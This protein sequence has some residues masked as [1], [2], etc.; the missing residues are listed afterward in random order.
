MTDGAL[1]RGIR[2]H[3]PGN[4]RPGAAWA[5]IEGTDS[6]GSAPGY[7]IFTDPIMGLRA[8]GKCMVAYQDL[9]GIHTLGGAFLRWAPSADGNDPCGYAHFVANRLGVGPSDTVDLH[10]RRT[11]EAIVRAIV[12]M[13]NGP[14]PAG[15]PADWYDDDTYGHAMALAVPTIAAAATN[16]VS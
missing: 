14:P 4:L 5:G 10:D 8:I 16:G 3:N 12:R 11:L 1:P 13:E 2:N 9:H 15:V 6:E 7:V